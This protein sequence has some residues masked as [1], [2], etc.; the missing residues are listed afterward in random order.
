MQPAF[1]NNPSAFSQKCF[2]MKLVTRPDAGNPD[3]LLAYVFDWYRVYTD[4]EGERTFQI[5]LKREDGVS[6]S[7]TYNN[8]ELLEAIRTGT[9]GKYF[10]GRRATYDGPIPPRKIP[11]HDFTFGEIPS[12]LI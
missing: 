1:Q 3:N 2:G 5:H 12:T 8:L 6:G 11:E 9:S 10:S 7:L 4:S